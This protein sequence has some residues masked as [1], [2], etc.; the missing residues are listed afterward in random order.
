MNKKEDLTK[1]EEFVRKNWETNFDKILDLMEVD[2]EML[3]YYAEPS[4]IYD[5]EKAYGCIERIEYLRKILGKSPLKENDQQIIKAFEEKYQQFMEEI[6]RQ[7][8]IWRNL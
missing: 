2:I 5:D 8:K 6:K 1:L 3:K 7:E 4:V